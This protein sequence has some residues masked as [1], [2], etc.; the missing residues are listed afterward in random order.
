MCIH[1]FCVYMRMFIFVYIHV[2]MFIFFALYICISLSQKTLF[3]SKL[4]QEAHDVVVSEPKVL[5]GTALSA[6]NR[7]VQCTCYAYMHLL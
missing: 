3:K 1:I 2:Y 4:D 5:A 7:E 6:L